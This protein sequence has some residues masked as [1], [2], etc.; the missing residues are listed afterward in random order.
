[1]III[2]N[3]THGLIHQTITLLYS[4]TQRLTNLQQQYH[5]YM[6]IVE[7]DAS[8][9]GHALYANMVNT[10]VGESALMDEPE[11]HDLLEIARFSMDP[12]NQTIRNI[13]RREIKTQEDVDD[14]LSLLT[15]K[16]ASSTIERFD[17]DNSL[18]TIVTLYEL[19]GW[20]IHRTIEGGDIESP[21]TFFHDALIVDNQTIGQIHFCN[22]VPTL[23]ISL[24]YYSLASSVM[25]E[26][27]IGLIPALSLL[28]SCTSPF[29]CDGGDISEDYSSLSSI[30]SVLDFE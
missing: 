21:S 26:Q 25:Q 12:S 6:S 30:L 2:D 5:F 23:C 8:S 13:K 3:S 10:S 16:R 17:Q 24:T 14:L 27:L 18:C 20:I 9:I 11:I 1:M 22:L 15:H 7:M 28:Y 29:R 19:Y 4:H